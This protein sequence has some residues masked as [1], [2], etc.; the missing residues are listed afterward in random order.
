M[1][2]SGSGWRH[3]IRFVT[4]KH[5]RCSV[6]QALRRF[7][8]QCEQRGG[9]SPPVQA[10]APTMKR[11]ISATMLP[12]RHCGNPNRTPFP[13]VCA[14]RVQKSLGPA[15]LKS[16]QWGTK[17]VVHPARTGKVWGPAAVMWRPVAE[18]ECPK[19]HHPPW[20]SHPVPPFK[21]DASDIKLGGEQSNTECTHNRAEGRH[22]HLRT[23]G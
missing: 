14:D 8:S 10:T 23:H 11:S 9:P 3:P 4:G 13:S 6:C 2:C 20:D 1:A 18:Q 22:G 17:G 19:R 12:P 7:C 15:F 16:V 5:E 21:D